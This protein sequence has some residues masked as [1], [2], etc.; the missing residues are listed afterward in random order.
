VTGIPVVNATHGESFS[1]SQLFSYSDPLNSP[2]TEYDFW[3]NGTGGGHFLLTGVALPTGQDNFVTAA[4]LSQVML[5]IRFGTDTLWVRAY[6]GTVWGNWSNAFP[7]TAPIDNGPSITPNNPNIFSIQGQSFA[8]SS[9]FSYSDPYGSAATSYD[10]W[11]TGG[12][13]GYFSS[14]GTKLAA[15]Q[16]NVISASQLSQLSYHVGAGTDELWIR[17]NDGTVWGAWSTPFYVS[18]PTTISAGQTLEIASAT[19]EEISFASNTGT[20]KLDD[21]DDFSGTVAGMTGHDTIDF[22]DINFPNAQTPSYLGNTSGGIL[23]VTDGT[24]TANIALL[25]NYMAST[26]VASSD[27]DGGTSV[28]NPPANTNMVL[29]ATQHIA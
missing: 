20:L 23:T 16:D 15:N 19:S 25:G 14:N 27:G 26:F 21:S 2:A 4:Q 5:P 29:A 13:G 22:V 10:V 1:V 12:G 28:V 18:D 17:A 8:V 11:D 9:L 3:N 7:V 24:H 6:D